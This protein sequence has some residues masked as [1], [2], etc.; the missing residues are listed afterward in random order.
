MRAQ[1]GS[2]PQVIVH[3]RYGTQCI[4]AKS[5]RAISENAQRLLAFAGTKPAAY[6]SIPYM[7]VSGFQRARHLCGL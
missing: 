2:N 4:P 1:S 5:P 6:L 3:M 7:A